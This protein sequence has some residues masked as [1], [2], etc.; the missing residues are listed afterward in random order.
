MILYNRTVLYKTTVTHICC[1][2]IVLIHMHALRYQ[3]KV[4]TAFKIFK[5]IH[6]AT[7]KA[8]LALT[9]MLCAPYLLIQLVSSSH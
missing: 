1:C 5:L 3:P 7:T 9:H 6:I 4:W 8:S 2:V